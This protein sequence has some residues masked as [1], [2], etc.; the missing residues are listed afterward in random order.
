MAP[1][2]RSIPSARHTGA[3][4]ALPGSKRGSRPPMGSGKEVAGRHHL[5][6]PPHRRSIGASTSS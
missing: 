4:S 1:G 2:C 6:R 5:F 3:P